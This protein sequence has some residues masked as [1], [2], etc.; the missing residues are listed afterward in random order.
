M[1]TSPARRVKVGFHCYQ[2]HTTMPELRR[3][4]REVD[5]FGADSIWPLDHFIPINGDR[6]GRRSPHRH[7]GA[8]AAR[9]PE[10]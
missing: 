1:A 4:W 9:V 7:T 3:M 5:A 6:A 10:R 8:A 2:E